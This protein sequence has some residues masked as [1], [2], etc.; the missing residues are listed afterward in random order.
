MQPITRS[1]RIAF[2]SVIV[3]AHLVFSPVWAGIE[4]LL[5]PPS[6]AVMSGQRFSVNVLFTNFEILD[7]C[8]DVPESLTA[9]MPTADQQH[10]VVLHRDPDQNHDRYNCHPEQALAPGQS[11]SLR[12]SG[13]LPLLDDARPAH[14]QTIFLADQPHQ[15][16]QFLVQNPGAFAAHTEHQNSTPNEEEEQ[17]IVK[18]VPNHDSRDEE[19]QRNQFTDNFHVYEPIYF[20]VGSDP[21]NAK[22][23]VSFKYRFVDEDSRIAQNRPWLSNF[24]VAYT[25]TSFWDL[26]SESAPFRDTNF[27]PEVFYQF[28]DILLPTVSENLYFD[29]RFGYQHESNGQSGDDSRSLN[30]GYLEPAFHWNFADNYR[31]SLAPR[32]WTYSGGRDGNEDIRDFRGRSSLTA[33]L[34]QFDGF[35]LEAYLRGNPGKGNGSIQLDASYPISALSFFNLDFYLYG[36]F[37]TGYGESLL[38]YNIKDTRF[39]LGLGIVR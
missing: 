4:P 3:L 29:F 7:M 30:I 15:P 11:V 22:F 13:V 27:K 37:F 39:R 38:D 17:E 26:E 23:Q 8:F 35:Q 2:F 20:L 25:Q 10:E 16:A 14:I 5:I 32:I 28:N 36:Q 9:I 6:Q 18:I 1:T 19:T 24:Y 21:T 31:L 33:T 34:T 12:Y